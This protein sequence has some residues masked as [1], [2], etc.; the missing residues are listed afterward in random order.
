MFPEY[1]WLPDRTGLAHLPGRVCVPE[2]DRTRLCD[3]HLSRPAVPPSPRLLCPPLSLS[4]HACPVIAH[5]LSAPAAVS[6]LSVIC[7]CVCCLSACM[8][9]IYKSYNLSIIY[10]PVCHLSLHLLF[11]CCLS[12]H[13]C[14]SHPCI[15]LSTSLCLSPNVGTPIP[16]WTQL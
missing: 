12:V 6:R 15:S 1:T 10:L 2:S 8:S 3:A 4:L 9:A 13:L 14:M 11:I 5:F 16:L 7:L